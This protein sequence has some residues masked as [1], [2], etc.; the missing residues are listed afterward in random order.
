MSKIFFTD[1]VASTLKLRIIA[2]EWKEFNEFIIE[3]KSNPQYQD[4]CLMLFH[5]Y[6]ENHFRF[7]IKAKTLA[8]DYG[9]QDDQK[10]F[11]DS[12]SGTKFWNEIENEI[13]ILEHVD[14][15]ELDQLSKLR[16]KEIDAFEQIL[17]EKIPIDAVFEEIQT[18]KEAAR[19]LRQNESSNVSRKEILQICRDFMKVS[20]NSAANS[21]AEVESDI[22]LETLHSDVISSSKKKAGTSNRKS[23]EGKKNKKMKGKQN[24]TSDSDEETVVK[25]TN[26]KGYQL[27]RVAKTINPLEFPEK[28]KNCYE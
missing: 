1:D 16:E 28:L 14:V 17:P 11:Y 13:T 26:R 8:L 9:L 22:D 25:T 3:T 23:Q 24:E 19:R 2:Q 4:I 15:V 10:D 6:T 20:G 7:T 27:Q 12:T 18:F 21:V 5:L